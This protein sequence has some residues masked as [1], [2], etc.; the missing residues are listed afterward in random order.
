MALVA[1]TWYSLAFTDPTAANNPPWDPA[2]FPSI[3]FGILNSVLT[4]TA[5]LAFCVATDGTT[6]QLAY[7]GGEALSIPDAACIVVATPPMNTQSLDSGEIWYSVRSGTAWLWYSATAG[8]VQ[9][10]ANSTTLGAFIS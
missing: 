7:L 2:L 1:S 5:I 9:S 6:V 3:P 8:N 10:I 4:A